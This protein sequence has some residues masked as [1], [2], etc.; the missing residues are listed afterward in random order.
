MHKLFVVVPETTISHVVFFFCLFTD[1]ILQYTH[2]SL[3]TLFIIM[4]SID[5]KFIYGTCVFLLE[6]YCLIFALLI[7]KNMKFIGIY[8]FLEGDYSNGHWVLF[9]MG[10]GC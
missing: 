1:V 9:S 4:D 8:F 7:L 5:K 10:A 3:C 2:L 6:K